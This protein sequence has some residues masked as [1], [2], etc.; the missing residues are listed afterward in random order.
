MNTMP[1][2]QRDVPRHIILH[3][4]GSGSGVALITLNL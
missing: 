1:G 4:L 2:R 3:D